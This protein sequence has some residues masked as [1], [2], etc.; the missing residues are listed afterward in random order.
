MTNESWPIIMLIGKNGQLGWELQRTLAPLGKIIALDRQQLDLSNP[1]QI[2]ERVREIKPR[3]IIN[4]AAYTGVDQ[5]EKEEAL[6]REV[7][8]VAPGLLA[9]EAKRL[10]AGIVH[11][12]TDYVFDGER[13]HPYTEEDD[14]KPQNMYGKS[15]LEG[16]KAIQAIGIPYLILRTSWL[17]G[18]RGDNFLLK[19]LKLSQE[20]K[21]L[22][23]VDDQL[24]SPT[25]SRMV[26]EGTAQILAQVHMNLCDK[27]G[28]YHL[29]SAGYTSWYGFAQ[30][31]LEMAGE[32]VPN[33]I[34]VFPIATSDY[35]S[36]AQR[37][38]DSR[39]CIHK[40]SNIFGIRLPFWRDSLELAI[41]SYI[42]SV[43]R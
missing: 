30:A 12:S 19:I 14:P 1:D 13:N 35:L 17:F 10:K 42:P 39:L 3:L 40:L 15:K 33:S 31:I 6:A 21:E 11:Y 38:L 2:R 25:W 20:K 22:R 41:S 23:I 5:A 16:E 26:A 29:S 36:L 18:M 43:M 4:A 27:G 7:N 32:L 37:P 28:V 24:G 34:N 9:E 8:G